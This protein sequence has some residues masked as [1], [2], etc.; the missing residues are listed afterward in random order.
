MSLFYKWT[1][2][3]IGANYFYFFRKDSKMNLII[4]FRNC[5]NGEGPDYFTEGERRR[6]KQR[7]AVNMCVDTSPS[8]IVLV[9]VII[10]RRNPMFL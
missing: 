1:V 4:V 7:L 5:S 2:N 8:Q 6:I 3:F 9:V 10:N